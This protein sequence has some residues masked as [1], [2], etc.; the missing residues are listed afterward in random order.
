MNL[1]VIYGRKKSG[2]TT[3]LLNEMI[4]KDKV[5]YIVPEQNVFNAEKLILSELG[6]EKA[7]LMETLSFKKLALNVLKKRDDYSTIRFI[8]NDTKNLLLN[9]V[10]SERRQELE[11]FKNGA[12][13]PEFAESVAS[14]ISEFKRYMIGTDALLEAA[15]NSELPE[16]LRKKIRDIKTIYA[17]YESEI[18][19]T[20]KDYDD[21]LLMAAKE[22][23]ENN[24]F[25]GSNVFVDCFTGFTEQEL[26]IIK[27]LINNKCNVTVSLLCDKGHNS[28][29]DLF[30]TTGITK[31]KLRKAADETG[32][33][34]S[35]EFFEKSFYKNEECGFLEKNFYNH[36]YQSCNKKAES[37]KIYSLKNSYEECENAI[38]EMIRIIGEDNAKFGDFVFVLCS[39]D[40][41]KKDVETLFAEYGISYYIDEKTSVADLSAAGFVT[42]VSDIAQYPGNREYLMSYLKSGYVI[43]NFRDEV[44]NF[45]NFVRE[46]GVKNYELFSGKSIEET[47]ETKSKYGF[48]PSSENAVKFVYE[49]AILPLKI[50]ISRVKGKHTA[51]E[52]GEFII[53]FLEN[54]CYKETIEEYINEFNRNG[55]LIKG[56]QFAQVY[57]TVTE[58]IRRTSLIMDNKV[59]DFKTFAD[60][61]KMAYESH[62]ISTIPL[63]M[64]SVHVTGMNGTGNGKFKYMFVL[65][66]TEGVIP[67]GFASESLINEIDRAYLNEIGIGLSMSKQLKLSEE[68]LLIYNAV[69]SDVD[70]LVMSYPKT[71]FSLD[72]LS[73]SEV[74][75]SIR[76]IF[77]ENPVFTGKSD[78]K[79]TSK[80]LLFER[81]INDIKKGYDDE[82]TVNTFK[83]FLN[84]DEYKYTAQRVYKNIIFKT[85]KQNIKIDKNLVSKRFDNELETAVTGLEKY[86]SCAFSYYLR[87]VLKCREKKEFTVN[88]ADAGSLSHKI[89]EDFS[90]MI[91]EK[92][93]SFEELTDTFIEENIENIAEEVVQNEYGGLFVSDAKS[94]YLVKKLKRISRRVINLIK[95]HFQK[96][97][98]VPLGYEMYFSEKNGMLDGIRFD[99]ED[100]RRV[101]LK[102][103]ID[104]VDKLTSDNT[105][106]IRVVDYKSSQKSIDLSDVY[107]GINLQL[108]FYL[109]VMLKQKIFEN[110]KPGAMLYLTLDEPLIKLNNPAGDDKVEFEIKKELKMSGVILDNEELICNMDSDYEEKHSSDIISGVRILKKTGNY[111][112]ENVLSE[113]EFLAILEHTKKTV[114]NLSKG[115]FDGDFGIYPLKNGDKTGCDYCPYGSVCGFDNTTCKFDVPDKLKKVEIMERVIDEQC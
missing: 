70:E 40:D 78:N 98:F 54:I 90:K 39:M 113:E 66:M 47:L 111:E 56:M 85:S 18:E 71:N 97:N 65:G 42:L 32:A 107:N 19:N 4:R 59:I 67:G 21:L 37:L 6:E 108:S 60:L 87:Y 10:I 115:I 83:Y 75:V 48:L 15:S 16:S 30:Y 69:C 3:A 104:R 99:L 73:P 95:L 80:R 43:K 25:C 114:E 102:G 29:G 112:S 20:F 35:E 92:N 109:L 61:L 8:D 24:Y 58:A 89:I 101:L 62:S 12:S 110:V 105:D 82:E 76:N 51:E 55:D 72:K 93:I 50:F 53:D 36:T 88:V 38:N 44:F 13:R 5:L 86:R 45:E 14:Q 22:I 84:D 91:A 81:V 7:F 23:A 100:D 103:V 52:F 46:A 33:E 9:K 31:D 64:D 96:G 68:Q 57:N 77:P 27:V 17:A 79:V 2:K 94:K 106:Y 1:K 49:K 28:A 63:S 26:N 34:Y 41:Y 74:L 11:I